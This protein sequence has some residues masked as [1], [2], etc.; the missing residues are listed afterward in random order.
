MIYQSIVFLPL[1][2]A[3]LAVPVGRAMGD[4][5]A[6]VLTT[7]LLLAA[8]ALSWVVF[9]DVGFGG[10]TIKVPLMRWIQSGTLDIS[11]S[12]RIDT[13]TAVM[14]VVVTTVSSLVHLYSIG[15]MSEDPARSRFFAYL[16]LFTSI[17][18]AKVN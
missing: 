7:A 1:L 2:G 5:A 15:Y 12:L 9:V 11:W 8:A 6:E 14:L 13:L 4:R 10:A 3:L 18:M 16:S 17:S